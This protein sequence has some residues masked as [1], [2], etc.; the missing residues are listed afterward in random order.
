MINE[1][2]FWSANCDLPSCRESWDPGDY[3]NFDEEE[4]AQMMREDGWLVVSWDTFCSLDHF[5]T[6]RASPTTGTYR[7]KDHSEWA[8]HHGDTH[9]DGQTCCHGFHAFNQP[10]GIGHDYWCPEGQE[11]RRRERIARV[12]ASN[13]GADVSPTSRSWNSAS[14]S[15]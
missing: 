3:G 1:P 12:A 11:V 2:T 15:T 9:H 10:G 4:I 13:G 5:L 14:R 7:R 6:Y 8:R